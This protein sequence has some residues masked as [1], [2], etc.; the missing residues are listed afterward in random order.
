VATAEA[1]AV[2]QEGVSLGEECR[3]VDFRAAVCLWAGFLEAVTV[4]V[5]A[6]AEEAVLIRLIC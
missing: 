4:G 2:S 1:V 5:A 3:G 6:V